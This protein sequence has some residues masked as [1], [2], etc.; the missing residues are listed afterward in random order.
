MKQLSRRAILRGAGTAIALPFLDAMV[1]AFAGPVAKPVRRLGVVYVLQGLAVLHALSR[2]VRA[3]PALIAALYLA[4]MVAPKWV[5]PA[6][7]AIGLI[8]S[9]AALRARAAAPKFGA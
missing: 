6:V 4:C 7:A 3:R 5:L 8:E 1:P 2:R 9:V